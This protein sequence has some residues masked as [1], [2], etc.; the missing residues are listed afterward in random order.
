VV[1][2]NGGNLALLNAY[3]GTAEEVATRHPTFVK[4]PTVSHGFGINVNFDMIIQESGA[5]DR[6]SHRET[7]DKSVSDDREAFSVSDRCR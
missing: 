2:H 6:L 3:S 5:L 1:L 4:V 7:L